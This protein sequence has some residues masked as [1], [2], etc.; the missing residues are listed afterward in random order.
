MI[1]LRR[2]PTAFKLVQLRDRDPTAP[3][4][5]GKRYRMRP[6][7]IVL[8]AGDSMQP[9]S[10]FPS[11]GHQPRQWTP[12]V[13]DPLGFDTRIG[14]S[15]IALSGGQRQRIA[16]ARALFRRPPV[17]IL[18]EATSSLDTESER[19]IQENMDRLLEGRTA[20]VIAHRLSTI[21]G[22]DRIVVLEAGT[23][24]EDGTHEELMA[25]QGLYY[26][27]VSQQLEL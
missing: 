3:A 26:Y 8:Q 27:L 9:Q 10:R 17:V 24:V 2:L 7:G 23:I 12:R 22:A 15:G 18:D 20:F 21:K 16:I 6:A 25:R 1:R 19:A 11:P 13:T 4:G 14:E 5:A